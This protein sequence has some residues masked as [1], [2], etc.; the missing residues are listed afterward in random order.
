MKSIFF[1]ASRARFLQNVPASTHS[2]NPFRVHQLAYKRP[3]RTNEG[4]LHRGSPQH[5]RWVCAALKRNR[6]DKKAHTLFILYEILF[7]EAKKEL[8]NIIS[9]RKNLTSLLST[10]SFIRYCKTSCCGASEQ[11]HNQD[12][13]RIYRSDYESRFSNSSLFSKMHCI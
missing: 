10:H 6:Q 2:L 13:R 5:T 4:A 1:V 9:E 7:A 3:M 8:L 11:Q 12:L